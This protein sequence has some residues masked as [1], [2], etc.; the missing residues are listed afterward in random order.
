LMLINH[1]IKRS[2][3]FCYSIA[4]VIFEMGAGSAGVARRR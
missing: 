4:G 3:L 1:R 2:G